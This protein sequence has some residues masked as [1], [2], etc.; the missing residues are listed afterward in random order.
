[1]HTLRKEV[2]PV[3]CTANYITCL[4]YQQ[5]PIQL[6]SLLL[7]VVSRAL[8]ISDHVVLPM[9]I[10]EESSF[11]YFTKTAVIG[12]EV[13]IVGIFWAM[14]IC[15]KVM[16]SVFVYTDMLDIPRIKVNKFLSQVFKFAQHNPQV[17]KSLYN[18]N[19]KHVLFPNVVLQLIVS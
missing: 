12:F 10:L 18:T 7:V 4:K 17:I 19:T 1:M 11:S 9:H 6:F 14:R 15:E 2:Y 8:M 16:V 13:H 3:Y 5:G